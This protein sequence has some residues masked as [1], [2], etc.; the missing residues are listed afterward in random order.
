MK[1]Y[2][3]KIHRIT[4]PVPFPVQ[5]VNVYLINEDPVTLIDTGVK[6]DESLHVLEDSVRELGYGIGDIRRILITHGHVDHYGQARKVSAVSGAEIHIHRK[7]YQRIQSIGQFWRSLV[8]VLIQNGT[9]KDSLEEAIN[10]MKSA[11]RSLADPLDDV[12]FIEEG[13]EICFENMA[14]Q[15]ILCPGHSPGLICF[16]LE[17]GGI[18]FSGDHLL[19]NI[20]PNPII[21]LCKEGSGPQS[22]SLKKYL[23]S[24]RKIKDLEVSLVLPGHGEPIRDFKG[25][26]ERVFHHHEQRL[27]MIL[28]ILSPGQKTAYEISEALFP[29]A[30]SFEV[31]L[32]VSEVLG[33]L[34]ILFDEG[35]IA[36]RSKGGLDYYSRI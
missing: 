13:G 32:G 28:S 10:Y 21:D 31:F 2:T 18:L 19:D 5:T 33:H 30:R 15:P 26:L 23:D 12:C 9:P 11:I 16:Y 3:R 4:L 14:F 27:S 25:A 24:I 20:S 1:E 17:K 22:T 29:N 6:T 35:R 36:L 34:R 7:E 8:S